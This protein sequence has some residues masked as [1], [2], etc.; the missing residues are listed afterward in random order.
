[1]YACTQYTEGGGDELTAVTYL[2]Q[3]RR[4]VRALEVGAEELEEEELLRLAIAVHDVCVCSVGGGRGICGDGM[5]GAR[6][7]AASGGLH[8]YM[9][10]D[11]HR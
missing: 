2:L 3:Q 6:G 10:T 9:R 7:T 8:Q 1:M 4:L 11:T 5:M